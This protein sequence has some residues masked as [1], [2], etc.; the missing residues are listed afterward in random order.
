MTSSV[1][2]GARGA[3]RD[4]CHWPVNNAR[5]RRGGRFLFT[6]FGL[7]ASL[8]LATPSASISVITKTIAYD[9]GLATRLVKDPV[10]VVAVGFDCGSWPSTARIANHGTRCESS[11]TSAGLPAEVAAKNGVLL[12]G[13][14]E[15]AQASSLASKALALNVPVL[16][17]GA[18]L[19]A[20]EVLLAVEG[21]KTFIGE[22]AAKRLGSKFPPAVL[23]LATI[24]NRSPSEDEEPTVREIP[25]STDEYPEE[26]RQA[27]VDGVVKLR[28]SVDPEGTVTDAVVING[29]GFGLDEEAVRRVKR[30]KFNPGKRKGQIVATT[31]N[32]NF[33]FRLEEN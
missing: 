14:V 10:V 26:A 6:L 24:V 3:L 21:S 18:G 29:L 30:F 4:T 32:F 8:V 19:A 13:D 11:A 31:L 22:Q 1:G 28:I 33:R 7:S 15:P 17:L 5:V 20:P 12:L 2:V 9:D 23:R 27:N 16:A 25:K